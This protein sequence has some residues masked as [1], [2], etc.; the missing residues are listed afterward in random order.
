MLMRTLA[1]ATLSASFT[2]AMADEGIATDR[3]DFVESSDVVAKGKAQLE[4][5]WNVERDKSAGQKSRQRSTPALLR[6]GLGNNLEAR[7]ETDG[8]LTTSLTDTNTGTTARQK[9][10]ADVALGLKWHTGDGDEKTG[11]PGTAWLLHID[12]PSGGSAYRGVGYR[13]S[14]RFVAE[15]ELPREWSVGVMPGLARDTDDN[16]R[17]FVAGILAVTASTAMARLC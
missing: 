8:L 17:S 12:A 11:T 2:L 4:L 5:G 13:P 14:L 15:W 10:A 9:G 6:I 1:L 3:P 7:I 16:G